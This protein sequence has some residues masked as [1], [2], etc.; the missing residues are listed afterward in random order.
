MNLLRDDDGT[1]GNN[2]KPA[3]NMLN[4]LILLAVVV[5]VSV[6]VFELFYRAPM[7]RRDA[8]KLHHMRERAMSV[9]NA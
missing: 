6:T 4:S 1:P 5:F 8:E 3:G 9:E 7:R 2:W